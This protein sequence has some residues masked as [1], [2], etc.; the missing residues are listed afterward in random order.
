VEDGD[1]E[2][3]AGNAGEPAAEERP[4]V[5]AGSLMRLRLGP[6]LDLNGHT[7]PDGTLVTFDVRYEGED[8]ALMMEPAITRNGMAVR[9]VT[10]DRSGILQ[11]SARAH[12][13]SSGNGIGIVIIPSITPTPPPIVL[14]TP[15]EAPPVVDGGA[16]GRGVALDR[17]NLVTLSIALFTLA[18]VLSLLLI[19]QIRVLPR[20]TLVHN[21]LWATIFGLSGYILYGI[22]LFPGGAWLRA[23][24]GV[25][26]T[27]VTVLVPMLLPLLWLQL[28]GD[29]R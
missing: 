12:D 1:G 29:E 21:M 7:V 24:V 2:V 27:P 23:N 6:I 28:R 5:V 20:P 4:A 9:E 11:I 13:A 10:P 16:L 8:V 18:V 3:I 25:W 15:E 26:G 17:V 22:G 19:V 14:I